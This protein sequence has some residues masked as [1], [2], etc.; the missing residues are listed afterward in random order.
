[1]SSVL[2]IP[3]WQVASGKHIAIASPRTSIWQLTWYLANK[4]ARV[5]YNG[6]ADLLPQ[7]NN[8]E[9]VQND[10][11]LELLPTTLTEGNIQDM[12]GFKTK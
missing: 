2:L 3:A 1:M 11:F 5:N 6:H 7:I 10:S 12:S 9:L 4:C 8:Q